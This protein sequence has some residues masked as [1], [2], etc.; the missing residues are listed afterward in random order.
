MKQS[1]GLCYYQK[2][3]RFYAS[4]RA[5]LP[6]DAAA[7]PP[8][9]APLVWLA[10]RPP[11]TGRTAFCPSSPRQLSA[12]AESVRFLDCDRLGKPS[13]TLPPPLRTQLSQRKLT[14]VNVRHP[15][16]E[17]ALTPALRAGRKRVNL[18]AVGDV[19]STLL[20]GLKLLGG[21]CISSIG[22]CDLDQNT[23]RRWTAELAQI[24]WPGSYDV[25][26]EVH[27]VEPSR[28]FDCDVFIFSAARGIPPVGSGTED[29]RMAQF[30]ANRPLVEQYARQARA[31]GFQGL[32]CVMSDP[33]DPL[34][35]A[36]FLASNQDAAGRWDGQGLFAEQ[37]RG[38]GLG[39]MNARA[40]A[41]AEQE[42]RY[43]AFLQEGRSFGPHGEGLI[44]ANSIEHYD[45][46]LSQ[47]LTCE[48]LAANLR[49]R[50]LGFKPYVA[51]ALSSGA[52]QLLL[53]LRGGWHCASVCL[54]SVWFGCRCRQTSAGLETE[55]LSMPDALFHRLLDT[56]QAL[57]KIV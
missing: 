11:E 46:Q 27:A 48:V 43:A 55:S 22:I 37:I 1:T 29:V 38:L 54:G 16:W 8:E 23:V 12:Q 28:L 5:G 14:A 56:E 32:F 42:P 30:G 3:G 50:A 44:L 17:Q 39:V 41:I 18:L 51:P 9:G 53:L 40:A 57:T 25:L 34:C 47:E 13:V 36:A 49:I 10:D 45:D 31:C 20:I 24:S 7:Q 2:S 6:L 15:R 33:V 52:L 21:D 35:R 19:G 4:D 26:P